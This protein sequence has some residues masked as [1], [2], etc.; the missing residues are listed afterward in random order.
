MMDDLRVAEDAEVLGMTEHEAA[1]YHEVNAH[2]FED[3]PASDPAVVSDGV[4]L[5]VVLSLDEFTADTLTEAAGLA[6]MSVEEYLVEN[7]MM[8]A[9][10]TAQ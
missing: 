5:V 9:A 4:K 10:D 3:A 6:G 1:L 2:R 8:R 7:A